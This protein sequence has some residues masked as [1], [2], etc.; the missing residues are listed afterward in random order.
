MRK[1]CENAQFPQTFRG[2]N[3][4]SMKAVCFK[5]ISSPENKVKFRYFK[6]WYKK[7]RQAGSIMQKIFN[8]LYVRS[9]WKCTVSFIQTFY[10]QSIT[11][12]ETFIRLVNFFL[13]ERCLS[14]RY[15][16]VR[17]T[18]QRNSCHNNF[19]DGLNLNVVMPE[20]NEGYFHQWKCS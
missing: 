17:L 11:S 10:F 5:K 8:D 9:L 20:K 1:F 18:I 12:H 7:A 14:I 16:C 4:N 13:R 2:V 6:Q 19:C 15:H 3:R